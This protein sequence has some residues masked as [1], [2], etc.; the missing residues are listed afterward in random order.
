MSLSDS[1]VF[2]NER[3]SFCRDTIRCT[4]NEMWGQGDRVAC[5]AITPDTK[6]VF[7]S[8][9]A[10]VHLFIKINR[11]MWDFDMTFYDARDLS[12]FPP[13]CTNACS[14]ITEEGSMRIPTVW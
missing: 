6:V 13:V 7:R 12:E 10:M 14:K 1:V 4:V 8:T 5:G 3:I 2:L 11:E 9:T